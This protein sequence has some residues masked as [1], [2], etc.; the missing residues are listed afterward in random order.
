MLRYRLPSR[1]EPMPRGEQ[2]ADL[3]Q[4]LSVASGEFVEDETPCL[5]VESPE[6]VRHPTHDRQV[7]ACISMPP[8]YG[9]TKTGGSPDI[10][11]IAAAIWLGD[12]MSPT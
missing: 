1:T 7:D 3:E 8:S 5:V 10:P 11:A 4:G 12:P 9:S 6:H 2:S